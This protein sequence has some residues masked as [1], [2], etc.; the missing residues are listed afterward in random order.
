MTVKSQLE[1]DLKDALRAGDDL[2]KRT[3]RMALAAIKQTEIDKGITLDDSGV[4]AIL[5]KEIKSR[6]ESIAD[7]ERAHRQ[8]LVDASRAEIT[9]LEGY[10]PKALTPQELEDLARQ[11]IAEAG[12]TSPAQMGQ[13]MKLLMPRLQ[14]RATGD[15]ASQVARRLLAG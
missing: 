14:G 6:H 11:V 2:R 12:A 13:V 15:A 1:N 9:V 7:A 4:M 10:L 3:L 5:Q 8:D